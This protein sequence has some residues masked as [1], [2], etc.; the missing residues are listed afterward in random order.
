MLVCS[1]VLWLGKLAHHTEG[2]LMSNSTSAMPVNSPSLLRTIL[3]VMVIVLIAYAMWL[4]KDILM[5]TLTAVIFAVLL[6]T[7]IR[8]F[9]RRGVPRPAAVLITLVLV[10]GL[11]FVTAAIL[12]P[13]LFEQFR[14]LI[15]IY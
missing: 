9:V 2:D 4:V 15:S 11:I 14:D 10:V 1:R 12:L 7:P 5:L 13:G 3:M 6:T 8:F